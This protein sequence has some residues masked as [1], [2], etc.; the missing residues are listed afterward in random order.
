MQ[1]EELA[2]SRWQD[3]NF[4]STMLVSEVTQFD[5]WKL[6]EHRH[7]VIN[8]LEVTLLAQFEVTITLTFDLI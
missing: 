6:Q 4:M 2:T 8:Y 5:A 3:F 1:T 7:C